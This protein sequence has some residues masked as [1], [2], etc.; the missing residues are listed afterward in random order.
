MKQRTKKNIALL[1]VGATIFI[2]TIILWASLDLT[3]SFWKYILMI[4]GAGIFS[5]GW[6]DL[7]SQENNHEL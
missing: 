1:I 4:I 7:E 3:G 2:G 5:K 6:R